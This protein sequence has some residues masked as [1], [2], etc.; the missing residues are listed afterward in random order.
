MGLGN[1]ELDDEPIS[2][3]NNRTI[4]NEDEGREKDVLKKIMTPSLVLL[5]WGS[6]FATGLRQRKDRSLQHPGRRT[7]ALL[8]EGTFRADD[9][10]FNGVCASVVSMNFSNVTMT[11]DAITP[12]NNFLCLTSLG[13]DVYYHGPGEDRCIVESLTK[14]EVP[15]LW[16]YHFP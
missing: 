13:L 6:G 16:D 5:C 12:G 9:A 14:A 10:F 11:D 2:V 4:Q 8:H 3:G 15:E 7:Y 1:D